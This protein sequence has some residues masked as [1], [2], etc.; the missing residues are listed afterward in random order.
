MR[1]ISGGSADYFDFIRSLPF[2]RKGPGTL[3]ELCDAPSAL[4]ARFFSGRS[5]RARLERVMGVFQSGGILYSDFTCRGGPEMLMA[6]HQAAMDRFGQPTGW[7]VLWR[8]SEPTD[9]LREMMMVTSASSTLSELFR[10]CTTTKS[11]QRQ[12]RKSDQVKMTIARR[13]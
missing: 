5:G 6:I 4:A 2:L 9:Y 8:G 3:S 12:S 11:T 1:T 7:L 10:M 13:A